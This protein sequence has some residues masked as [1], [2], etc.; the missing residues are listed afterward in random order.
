MDNGENSNFTALIKTY[1]GTYLTLAPQVPNPNS[2]I[3]TVSNANE[4]I[5]WQFQVFSL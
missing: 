2:A 4:A 5:S 3:V 1:S